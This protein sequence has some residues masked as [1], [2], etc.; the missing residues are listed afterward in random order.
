MTVRHVCGCPL[1]EGMETAGAKTTY[2]YLDDRPGKETR[3]QRV[4]RCP[5]CGAEITSSTVRFRS[6]P[7]PRGKGVC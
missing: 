2:Y 4:T 1:V 7:R 6:A 3:G 5:Y